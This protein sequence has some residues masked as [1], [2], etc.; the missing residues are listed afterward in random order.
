MPARDTFRGRLS[1]G[2][3]VG[4]W[5]MLDL[6]ELVEIMGVAGFDFVV[7]DLE[8]SAFGFDAVPR[9]LSA[10]ETSGISAIVR[11][12][13]KGSPH[14]AKALDL[15]ADGVL[16]PQVET[17]D[18]ARRAVAASKFAPLG[19]RG[20][21][22]RVRGARYGLTPSAEYYAAENR[23]RTT[24]VLV[25]SP[26]GFE[27]LDE[28]LSVDGLD[29]VFFGFTDLSHALGHAGQ[30]NHPEVVRRIDDAIARVKARGLAAGLSCYDEAEARRR[31]A[32]GV[33]FVT[34][35]GAEKLF[36]D[37]CRRTLAAVRGG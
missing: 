6:P 22:P 34:V 24:M 23:L 35:A 3:L 17:R 32:A 26:L 7:V 18:D 1:R 36:L 4:S 8:H 37:A 29:A 31:I 30:P 13:G 10:A 14:V 5:L 9:I 25:E 20:A 2:G 19:S 21:C 15:G 33:D 16:I 12:E 11:V 28:I 27:N